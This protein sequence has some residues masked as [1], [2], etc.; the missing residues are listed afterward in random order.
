MTKPDFSKDAIINKATLKKMLNCSDSYAYTLLNRLL[1]RGEI[2]KIIKTRYTTLDD[3]Y[4]IATNLFTPS[5]LSFWT[6]SYFKGYT[7]QVLSSVQVAVTKS[8]KSIS[9]ENYIIEPIKLNKKMFFGYKKIRHGNNSLFLAED[10][11]L[12]IDSIYKEKP[13]GNFDEMIKIVKAAKIDKNRL[14]EYLKRINNK[15]LIKRIGFLLEK[16]RNIDISDS[17]KFKDKNYIAL[18]R[19]TKNKKIDTKWMVKHDI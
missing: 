16:Y 1:R 17:I 19:Y 11:K 18:S 12:L 3:I 15:S 8:K 5:Y 4:L 14:I 2:K 13:M 10:E 7:E 6:A 9:F